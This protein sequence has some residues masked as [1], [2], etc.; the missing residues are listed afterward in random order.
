MKLLIQLAFLWILWL[1]SPR[2]WQQMLAVL[3]GAIAVV[4][5]SISPLGIQIGMRG[6]TM[7]VPPDNGEVVDAIVV[8]GR[9]T[10]FRDLR[11]LTAAELWQSQR[12]PR[13]FA[14]GMMDARSIVH[15][16]VE[17]GVPTQYLSG[18]ECSQ[19][20]HENALFTAAILHPQNKQSILLVTDSPHTWRALLNFQHVGFHVISHSV[21]LPAELTQKQKLVFIF[22]EY[23]A[24][25]RDTLTGGLIPTLSR[26][27]DI[28]SME[29]TARIRDWKCQV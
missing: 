27:S 5:V 23:F 24:L 2:R 15:N 28:S 20:T 10:A 14:S 11:V 17:L 12:A 7:W 13:I 19:S 9:G 25:I 29:I 26:N 8:L 1:I 18:E 22:R 16:L 6:L 3:L 21:S 4:L